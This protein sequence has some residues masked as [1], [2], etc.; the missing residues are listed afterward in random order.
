M[1]AGN[2]TYDS[3]KRAPLKRQNRP[4][5]SLNIDYSDQIARSKSPAIIL[6]RTN[7][8]SLTHTH[9]HTHSRRARAVSTYLLINKH[10]QHVADSGRVWALYYTHRTLYRKLKLNRTLYRTLDRTRHC[11]AFT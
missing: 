11:A 6:S 4:K 3:R 5:S 1:L 8:L 7:I 2:E 9:T 10:R